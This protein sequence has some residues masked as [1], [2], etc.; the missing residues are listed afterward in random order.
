MSNESNKADNRNFARAVVR[1]IPAEQLLD[2][3]CTVTEAREKFQGLPLG[4]RAIHI[5]D[6]NA[7]TYFL[8]TF[9]RAK[10]ETVSASEATT[11]PSLSQALHMLNGAAVHGKI[12]QGGAVKKL[13]AQEGMTPEKA[14]EALFFRCLTR[15]PTPDETG[16]LIAIVNAAPN[17]QTGLEDVFW[18]M[19][20]S[21]EFLFNH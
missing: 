19:L 9:G 1:R 12:A 11:D 5:A 17:P 18:A 6:G 2:C 20:N 7:S 21:R 10:R 8:T 13:L 3:I 16:R 14:L 15:K 4:A